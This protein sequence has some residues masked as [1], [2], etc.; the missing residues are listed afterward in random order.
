MASKQ[1]DEF[2]DDE[3]EDSEEDTE[4][5]DDEFE[6]DD[7]KSKWRHTDIRSVARTCQNITFGLRIIY[8]NHLKDRLVSILY[9]TN[10]SIIRKLRKLR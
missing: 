10:Q 9:W 3:V 2:L 7:T 6:E 1:N 5:L 4:Y 8:S